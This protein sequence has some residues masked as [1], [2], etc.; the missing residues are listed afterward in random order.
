MNSRPTCFGSFDFSSEKCS[1]CSSS[2]IDCILIS[3]QQELCFN[4]AILGNLNLCK[5]STCPG[6]IRKKCTST[7]YIIEKM[8]EMVCFSKPRIDNNVECLECK[9]LDECEAAELM[10]QNLDLTISKA[11]DLLKTQISEML[12]EEG[13]CFGDFSFE[14]ACWDECQWA[15]KC[16][17]MSGIIPGKN[18]KYY[19]AE[20]EKVNQCSRCNFKGFCERI[21]N[22]EREA[23]K[24]ALESTKIFRN[25]YDINKIREFMGV[26][27]G[28]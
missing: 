11:E 25:F 10:R 18:C 22:S 20:T 3:Q 19:N 23:K 27:D 15:L 13:Q 5:A 21:V 7:R 12:K 24:M 6:D 14:S 4:N 2:N 28:K 17:K 9:F 26:T 16:L 1:T 8:K